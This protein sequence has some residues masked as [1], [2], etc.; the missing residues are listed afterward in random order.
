LKEVVNLTPPSESGTSE[1]ETK[2]W[3]SL[4]LGVK[5]KKA[6]PQSSIWGIALALV[7]I[8]IAFAFASPY[9][10]TYLN[11]T[12]ILSATA[13]IAITAAVTGMLLVGRGIDLSIAAVMAL[14]G[15]TVAQL[16]SVGV[17]W[18]I[19]VVAALAAGA[20]VGAFNGYFVTYIGVNALIVTIGSQFLVRGIAYMVANNKEI[21]ITSPQI[22]WVGQGSFG[23]FPISGILTVLVFAF[24]GYLMRYR[25]FG[26]H[27]FAIGGAPV[28]ARLSGVP[29]NRRR[30][31]LFILSGVFAAVSG[32]VLA[33]YS[34]S[35]LAYA[36]NGVELQVIAAVILGGTGLMGGRGTTSGTLLGVLFIA[37][38]LNGMTLLSV[39]SYFQYVFEGGALLTAVAVDD[40]RRRKGGEVA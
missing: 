29:L 27:V 17:P 16:L 20:I 18:Y 23:G 12:N 11:L 4:G 1:N 14:S 2:G 8:C 32:L 6:F 31:Q 39:P 40:I 35:G 33:G 26:K 30:M 9:F 28:A 15:V 10:F 7:V 24:C 19:A 34:A 25:P 5:V 13:Y 21:T 36:A 38:F 22:Q 37:V 3:A